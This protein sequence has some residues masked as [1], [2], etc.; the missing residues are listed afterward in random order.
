MTQLRTATKSQVEEASIIFSTKYSV[1]SPKMVNAKTDLP[2]SLYIT[3]Y[4][5]SNIL[6]SEYIGASLKVSI[7]ERGRK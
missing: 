6:K 7:L 4:N 3:G 5:Q 1:S 2:H